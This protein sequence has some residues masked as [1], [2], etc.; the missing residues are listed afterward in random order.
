MAEPFPLQ[1]S[2]WHATAPAAVPTPPLAA[3]ATA[4]VCVI[5]A[6]YAGLS[7]ALHLAEAGVSVIVLETHEPGWGGSGRN[8]GQVIPGIKYD[9][10]EI[11]A[12]FGPDA[13]EALTRFVSTTADLVFDLIARH[14]MDVPHKR[15]GWI[16]GAHTP[17][18]AE[19]VKRRAAEWQARGVDAE[20]LNKDGV[21]GLLGT[22]RYLAAWIDRRAGGV[23]PLAY[24]RGLAKAALAAGA[25][26]HG[27]SKVV[28][29]KRNGANWVVR[30]A[31]GA[32]VT[33]PRVVVATNGYT[34]DLIPKLRQTVIRPNT[35]IVATQPLSD[36][37]AGT[38]L[39]AGQV[40]SD[41]RQ[42]L[43]YYRKDHQNRLLMGGRGPFREP[44]DASDWAHLERV[45]G[46][47]YPQA[48]GVPFEYRWCGRVALTRDFLPHL[49]EPEPGLLVDIGCM[50]RGVGLQSA[51]GK[52]M[53]EYI[54]SGDRG[55]LPFP[56]VPIKPLPLH[57][58]NELYVSA[59]ITWYRLTDGGMKDKAA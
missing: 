9:P 15:A 29:L 35:F 13:G 57:A 38:I 44:R 11:V 45:I 20:F 37:V 42:L 53:A 12:K 46:K 59:I 28:S 47:M 17:A 24:A 58:L 52:A 2:L 48:K 43:L 10:S 3:D 23:Q 26:M 5:G 41:T 32:S 51:M 1:P 50:G 40:T 18:M 33:A 8:G 36:N 55:R 7:T 34:G 31:Q 25:R 16:Q 39:P 6:G 19:T 56:V 22:D 54:A 21:A 27:Q 4:D 49:H 30:T 14:G